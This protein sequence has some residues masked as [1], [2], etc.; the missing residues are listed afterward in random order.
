MHATILLLSNVIMEVQEALL[1]SCTIGDFEAA[2][3]YLQQCIQYGVDLNFVM[4]DGTSLV[5]RTVI[6]AGI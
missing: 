6:S 4:D 1:N 3:T 2:S 5:A